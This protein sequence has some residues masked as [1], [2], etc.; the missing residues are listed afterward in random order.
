MPMRL[1]N[2]ALFIGEQSRYVIFYYFVTCTFLQMVVI[3]LYLCQI[4]VDMKRSLPKCN[5]NNIANYSN[6]HS[7]N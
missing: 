5:Q 4:H 6:M 7:M 2:V 3:S 1:D